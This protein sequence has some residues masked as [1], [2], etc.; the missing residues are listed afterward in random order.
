[1]DNIN[2]GLHIRTYTVIKNPSRKNLRNPGVFY[3]YIHL[4]LE[5]FDR[6][7]LGN[8]IVKDQPTLKQGK[9]IRKT[10]RRM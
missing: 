6:L 5:A 10:I 2:K 4:C 1:M 8:I 3:C 7:L 9:D